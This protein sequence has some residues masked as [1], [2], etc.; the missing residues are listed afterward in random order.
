MNKTVTDELL[1]ACKAA[2]SYLISV[3]IAA[4]NPEEP[5]TNEVTAAVA[6]AIQKAE[7]EPESYIDRAIRAAEAQDFDCATTWAAI[8]QA[9]KA[10]A[11]PYTLETFLKRIERA[12]VNHK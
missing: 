7:A 6:D 10:E 8:A 11:V 2:L 12:I 9:V 1:E 5:G 4:R 3:R